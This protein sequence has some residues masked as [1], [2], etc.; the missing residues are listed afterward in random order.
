[1]R[2]LIRRAGHLSGFYFVKAKPLAHFP[3]ENS[4]A[5]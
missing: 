2:T 4:M 3:S 1:M 5:V